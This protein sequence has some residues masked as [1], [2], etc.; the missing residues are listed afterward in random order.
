MSDFKLLGH[1]RKRLLAEDYRPLVFSCTNRR[2]VKPN[3]CEP[4]ARYVLS[5]SR[6]YTVYDEEAGSFRIP[7]GPLWWIIV[8]SAKRQLDGS[9]LVKFD[10]MD[11]R[12]PDQFL[13]GTPPVHGVEAKVPKGDGADESAY[14]STRWKSPD[15][16]PV[17]RKDWRE[18]YYRRVGVVERDHLLRVK[19]AAAARVERRRRRYLR[20][21]AA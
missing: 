8:R 1:Q 19:R 21:K 5:W 16:A 20:K 6:S 13:R 9:W 7:R 3:G 2:D 11:R 12:D 17:V 15:T 10:V 14:Q 4:G 18:D